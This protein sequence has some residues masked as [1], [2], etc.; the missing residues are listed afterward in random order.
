MKSANVLNGYLRI[1]E[2]MVRAIDF[3]SHNAKE[4]LIKTQVAL[5]N[6]FDEFLEA[7]YD[8]AGVTTEDL[9]KYCEAEV[10]DEQLIKMASHQP[11]YLRKISDSGMT[12]GN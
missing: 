6:D 2:L 8:A 7:L 10:D 12:Q 11:E 4:E 9:K 5:M 3:S 1:N